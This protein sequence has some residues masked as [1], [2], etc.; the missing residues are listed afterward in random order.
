MWF[1]FAVQRAAMVRLGSDSFDITGSNNGRGAILGL[2][3]RHVLLTDMQNPKE[4]MI[5]IVVMMANK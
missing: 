1:L 3:V 4:V 2:P 5:I